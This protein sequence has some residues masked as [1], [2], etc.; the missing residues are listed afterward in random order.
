MSNGKSTKF[1]SLLLVITAMLRTLFNAFDMQL[2]CIYHYCCG[3]SIVIVHSQ[4]HD[5]F[6]KVCPL[7][8]TIRRVKRFEIVSPFN[9]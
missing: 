1:R 4:L 9:L 2:Q 3:L 5:F 7:M 6:G 8:S